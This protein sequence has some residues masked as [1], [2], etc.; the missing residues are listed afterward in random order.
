MVVS[1]H[2]GMEHL[3]RETSTRVQGRSEGCSRLASTPSRRSA[4]G[5]GQSV[6]G[7]VDAFPDGIAMCQDR[8]EL[9]LNASG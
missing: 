6:T 2:Y 9:S 7:G 1:V 5:C 8:V 4:R 3:L